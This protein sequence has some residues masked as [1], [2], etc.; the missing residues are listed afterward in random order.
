MLSIRW[1][2]ELLSQCI[3]E[4]F[5]PRQI[6][7]ATIW[8]Q[9]PTQLKVLQF[10]LFQLRTF[11]HLIFDHIEYTTTYVEILNSTALEEIILP[12]SATINEHNVINTHLA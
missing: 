3:I 1:S 11:D 12:S 10:R 5:N 6:S 9:L 2:C 4:H 7:L 8:A